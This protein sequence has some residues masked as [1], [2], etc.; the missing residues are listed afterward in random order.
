MPKKGDKISDETREKIRAANI[1][2]KLSD[3]TRKKISNANKGKIMS[4]ENREKLRVANI[5]RKCSDETRKK[6]S[7]A[8]KGKHISPEHREKI[9]LA[10]TG[11]RHRNWK[12]DDVK[13]S[14]LHQWVNRTYKEE[15]QKCE[16]C[17]STKRINAACIKEYA[18][19][20]ENWRFL[21]NVCHQRLHAS[22]M[23]EE[24]RKKMRDS[25]L[26]KKLP[27]EQK[28]KLVEGLQRYWNNRKEQ[29]M[30]KREV[31]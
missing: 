22:T 30:K 18:R 24:T 19:P 17:G 28:R 1:G 5:G 7:I 2:K 6:I 21:C 27:E 15:N 3:E 11:E 9:R 25:H 29:E 12:G 8:F 26:G 23:S 10:N 31:E 13:M 20:R 16:E 4:T 14:A